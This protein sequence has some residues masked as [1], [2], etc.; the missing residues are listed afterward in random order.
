MIEILAM[1]TV[2]TPITSGF[3]EVVKK[4][5]VMPV[6]FIPL[7]G[8]LIGMILG[9]FA[10]FLD[11]SLSIRLWVGGIS[12]LASVGVFEITKESTKLRERG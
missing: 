5:A 11:A 1:A 7:L 9:S 10:V 8:I 4:T 6:R 12:G 3:I 2:L